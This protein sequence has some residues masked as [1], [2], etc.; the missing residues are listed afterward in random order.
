[1]LKKKP[2][3]KNK[4]SRKSL[5]EMPAPPAPQIN[6]SD[7]I[8]NPEGNEELSGT[9]DEAPIADSDE[10]RNTETNVE[11]VGDEDTV[12]SWE[13][14]PAG[15]YL[16]PDENGTVWFRANDGNNWYQNADESWTKWK[17]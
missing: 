6:P 3:P 15:D 11:E 13:G 2:Q 7:S 5:A 10:K 8:N 14:L 1:M 12:E 9:D 16:D 4:P 17:D